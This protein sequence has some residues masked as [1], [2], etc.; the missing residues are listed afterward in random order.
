[1]IS[2]FTSLASASRVNYYVTRIKRLFIGPE[3]VDGRASFRVVI[4]M[5]SAVPFGLNSLQRT[6]F[7]GD[8]HLRL[9][10]GHH[11]LRRGAEIKQLVSLPEL[12]AHLD[13]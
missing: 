6:L 2:K 13:I 10:V 7:Q 8:R 1:M 11:R 12:I 5:V 9:I 4:P 3:R